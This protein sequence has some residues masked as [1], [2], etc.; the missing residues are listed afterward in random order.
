[1]AGR[2][3]LV[4]LKKRIAEDDL[5]DE[6][7]EAIADGIPIGKMCEMFGISSR[8][9]FYD[10]KKNSPKLEEKFQAARKFSAEAHAE[11]AGEVLDKVGESKLLT[12]PEVALAMGKVKYRQWLAGVRDKEQY[13]T[14]D[15]ANIQINIGDL[16]MAALQSPGARPQIAGAVSLEPEIPEA[17]YE[18]IEGVKETSKDGEADAY[19]GNIEIR[20][21]TP[22]EFLA[23]E[24][25]ELL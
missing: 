8:K 19:S 9:M 15:K 5:E 4:A 7:F 1:M 24:L 16:H 14:Q 22:L 10:W 11:M 25:E 12:S 3:L 20:P 17:D 2:P 18:E 6:I 13:G 21:S 23:P